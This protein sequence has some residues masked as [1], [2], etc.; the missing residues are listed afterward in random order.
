VGFLCCERHQ[1]S[2]TA[3]FRFL[4]RREFC[5]GFCGVFV[6]IVTGTRSAIELPDQ[7]DRVFYVLIVLTR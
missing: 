5:V 3:F 1:L 7:K 6:W 2:L 4:K